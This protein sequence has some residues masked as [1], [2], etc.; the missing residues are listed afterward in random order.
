M[1]YNFVNI[2]NICIFI[3]I[4]TKYNII[5]KLCTLKNIEYL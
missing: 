4:Y 1:N 2:K 5:L 3:Y